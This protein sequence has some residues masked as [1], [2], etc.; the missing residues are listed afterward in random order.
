MSVLPQ[1]NHSVLFVPTCLTVDRFVSTGRL[2]TVGQKF[3]RFGRRLPID[4]PERPATGAV[5]RTGSAVAL[6]ERWRR[7]HAVA[8][9]NHAGHGRPDRLRGLVERRLR[10]HAGQ[11]FAGARPVCRQ[12]AMRP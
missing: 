1:I 2:K 5:R 3:G 4:Q 11:T 12:H 7:R 8:D 6:L 10:G 9:N